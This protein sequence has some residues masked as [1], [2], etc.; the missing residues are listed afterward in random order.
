MGI[1][2]H[3]QQRLRFKLSAKESVPAQSRRDGVPRISRLP[4]L[5]MGR[6]FGKLSRIDDHE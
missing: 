3:E 1:L 4:K 5:P 6:D 2:A